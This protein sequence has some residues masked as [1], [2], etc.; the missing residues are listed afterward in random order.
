MSC[1]EEFRGR[2]EERDMAQESACAGPCLRFW[3]ET[4]PCFTLRELS[5]GPHSAHTAG[6]NS[7]LAGPCWTVG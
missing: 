6:F 1:A 3:R 4:A 7:C 2:E 5:W